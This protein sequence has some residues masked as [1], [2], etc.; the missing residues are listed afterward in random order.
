MDRVNPKARRDTYGS[1]IGRVHSPIR[2]YSVPSLSILI[3]S[4][5]PILFMASA[6]PLI[7]PL[8]FL[9]LLGWRLVRPGLLPIWAGFPLGLFDDLFSGQPFGSAILL[10][11]ITMITIELIE[12]QL[13]RRNFAQDWLIFGVIILS[14]IYVAAIFSGGEIATP[15]MLAT[16]PQALLSVLVFPIIARM[17]ARL[18]RL[19]L[20]RVRKVR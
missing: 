13:P 10:W 9:M 14:Y 1:R 19:R 7:P 12:N 18:D 6:V 16:A 15:V 11:S 3:A 4:L 8:G 2:A 20:K 5:V 17:V